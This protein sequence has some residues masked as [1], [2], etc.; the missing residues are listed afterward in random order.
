[1]CK[2]HGVLLLIVRT[3]VASVTTLYETLRVIGS[4]TGSAIGGAIWTHVLFSRLL[5]Y[6]PDASKNK[7]GAIRDSF[8]FASSFPVGSLERTAINNSY[9][10]VMHIQFVVTLGF[11]GASFLASLFIQDVDLKEMD[12]SKQSE[13]SSLR[14]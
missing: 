8:T 5:I 6:L 3:D 10:D 2:R 11:M 9:T 7:A 12:K 13:A 4:A 1:M 14:F